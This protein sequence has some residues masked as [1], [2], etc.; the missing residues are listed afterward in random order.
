MAGVD[1]CLPFQEV[2][3]KEYCLRLS[4]TKR[5]SSPATQTPGQVSHSCYEDHHLDQVGDFLRLYMECGI[6]TTIFIL[7]VVGC[8][9]PISWGQPC[10]WL[11]SRQILCL[12]QPL[13]RH[14]RSLGP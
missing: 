14:D 8:S 9:R 1:I 13:C 6:A 3:R 4:N 11:L 2:C 12:L 5:A 10:A 7:E